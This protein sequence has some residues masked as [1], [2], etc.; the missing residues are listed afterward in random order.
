MQF[1]H[2][3]YDI[4]RSCFLT[5]TRMTTHKSLRIGLI[6]C[7]RIASTYI[8]AV[9]AVTHATIVALC[10]TDQA[11]MD[12]LVH[13]IDGSV[14][15]YTDYQALLQDD[16]VDVIAICTPPASHRQI[17]IDSMKAGKDVIVEKPLAMKF[18]DAKDM[19][20]VAT[21]YSRL[22][23]PVMQNRFNPPVRFLQTQR[24][25]VGTLQYVNASC[26]WYRPQSYYDD[27]WHGKKDLEGGV[28]MNQGIHYVDM[29]CHVVESTPKHVFAFGGNYGHAM[30]SEDVVSLQ[31]KFHNDVIGSCQ[32]NTISYPENLEG[33]I[34]MC[35]EHATVKIGGKAMDEIVS[36]Q[37]LGE[38]AYRAVSFPDTADTVYGYGHIG[39]IQNMYDV[40]FHHAPAY[41]TKDEVLS[42]LEIVEA[43]YASMESGESVRIS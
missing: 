12:A 11:R 17:A 29:M 41:I 42:T 16:T 10:D 8:H 9:H 6:G 33:S 2:I 30:E 5:E 1:L 19:F 3:W 14:R 4:Y 24:D 38:D 36:W 26:F 35:F 27:G 18:S 34:T 23:L 37:G 32:V 31:V 40:M 39:V 22:L 7:G 28:L 13:T 43:S 25:V 15:M 20:D 21:E